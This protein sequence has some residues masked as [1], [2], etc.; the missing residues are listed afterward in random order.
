MILRNR[1][2]QYLV[3]NV[4]FLSYMLIYWI[5]LFHE[6]LEILEAA[7]EREPI[8]LVEDVWQLLTKNL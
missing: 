6:D 3:E 1:N 4:G 2:K 8:I 5:M 7:K